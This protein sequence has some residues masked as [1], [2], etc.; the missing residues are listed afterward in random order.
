MSHLPCNCTGHCRHPGRSDC[1]LR[2]ETVDTLGYPGFGFFNQPA[3]ADDSCKVD[4]PAP[5]ESTGCSD[6]GSDA[7]GGGD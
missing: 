4:A 1:R 2:N 5:Q 6:G 7:G 3:Q